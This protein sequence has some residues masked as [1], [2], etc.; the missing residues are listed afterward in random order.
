M[1]YPEDGLDEAWTNRT[2]T[3]KRMRNAT[4]SNRRLKK[5]FEEPFPLQML[6]P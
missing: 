4:A 5:V 3:R 6:F 2:L 1:N